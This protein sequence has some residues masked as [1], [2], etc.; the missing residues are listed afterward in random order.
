MVDDLGLLENLITKYKSENDNKKKQ[1][2]YLNLVSETLKLVKKIASGIHPLPPGVGNDDL[3]QVGALGVLKAIDLYKVEDKGSFKT[4]VSICIKG[5]IL[6]FLRDKAYTI[7]PPRDL[8]ENETRNIISLDEAVFSADGAETVLDRISDEDFEQTYENKKM[9][10][11]ALNKL[12]NQEK[13]AIYKY[14]IEGL[15]K[16]E[17]AQELGV[18][19]MQVTRLIKRALKKM[20]KIISKDIKE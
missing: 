1:L 9:I 18:S 16:K 13:E 5:K 17:I 15:K 19:A 3:I 12:A 2:A 10:E 7:K 6:Q 20:Y 4:Y 8:K 11:F 14:Y